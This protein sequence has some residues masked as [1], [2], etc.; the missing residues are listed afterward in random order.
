MKK[1]FYAIFPYMMIV[2]FSLSFSSS[3]KDISNAEDL[4]T[5]ICSSLFG[6]VVGGVFV[7]F[8][9]EK[10]WNWYINK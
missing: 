9:F 10:F 8:V 1:Q 6:T 5:Q 2:N 3:I 7:V 4:L